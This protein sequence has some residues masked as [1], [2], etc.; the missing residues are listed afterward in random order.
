MF[1]YLGGSLFGK[2]KL[3]PHVSPKKTY[4][5][6]ISAIIGATLF[7]VLTMIVFN[8]INGVPYKDYD[9][10][11]SAFLGQQLPESL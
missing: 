6:F 11:Q 10:P 1:G 7:I 4:A 9:T 8:H 2:H 5:G 3:A